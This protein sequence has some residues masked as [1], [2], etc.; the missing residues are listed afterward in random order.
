MREAAKALDD[1][2][3]LLG[4]VELVIVAEVDEQQHR[5]VLVVEILAVLERH[6]EELALGR[7]ELLVEAL[8]DR[9]LGDRE[10]Q[11]IGR[12]LLGMA[13]EHV[14]RE[15]VEQDHAGERGQRIAEE[16]FDRQLPLFDP[17]LEEALLDLLVELRSRRSTIA[18]A[19]ARTR[20]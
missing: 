7:C 4:I 19:S 1:V 17:E 13:A 18:P 9:S 5:A 12:E 6:V 15:L 11:M 10:R 16:G 20:I 8:V 2:A 3:V 14:A